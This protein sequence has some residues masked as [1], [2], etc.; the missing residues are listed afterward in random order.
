VIAAKLFPRGEVKW[1][2]VQISVVVAFIQTSYVSLIVGKPFTILDSEALKAVEE[3]VSLR[4]AL[5]QR[6]AGPNYPEKSN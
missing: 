6:S 5:T 3:K 4:V 2:P 1:S